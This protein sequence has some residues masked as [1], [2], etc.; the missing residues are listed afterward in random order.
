[1][2]H[3]NNH[4]VTKQKYLFIF[5]IPNQSIQVKSDYHMPRL[6]Y[7][8]THKSNLVRQLRSTTKN[9]DIQRYSYQIDFKEN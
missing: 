5:R 8:Y 7:Y 9:T 1:M 4:I 3:M 2:H 6:V